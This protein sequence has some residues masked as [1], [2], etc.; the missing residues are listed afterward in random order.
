MTTT[1]IGIEVRDIKLSDDI[2]R[3]AA[4]CNRNF[5]CL[6]LKKRDMCEAEYAL[7]DKFLFV[8]GNGPIYCSYRMFY[9][10]GR[11]CT[12]PVR[13]EIYRQYHV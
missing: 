7:N 9:G 2:L 10:D 5:S 11:V 6:D 8:K 12:C 1:D 4:D 13:M 3:K